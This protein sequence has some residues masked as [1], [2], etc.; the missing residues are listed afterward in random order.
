MEERKREEGI[1]ISIEFEKVKLNEENVQNEK[2]TI[3]IN[4]S[5]EEENGIK[6]MSLVKNIIIEVF[7]KS[8]MHGVSKIFQSKVFYLKIMWILFLLIS[9]LFFGVMSLFSRLDYIRFEVTTKIRTVYERPTFFPTVRM[10]NP[11]F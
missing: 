11:F 9:I 5:R 1:H 4:N 3:K 10:D 6:T 2:Q 7:S 8:T